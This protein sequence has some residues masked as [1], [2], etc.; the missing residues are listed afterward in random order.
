M[1]DNRHFSRTGAI[2]DLGA[3]RENMIA[4]VKAARE[5]NPEIKALAT[6]KADAYGHGACEV[7]NAVEDI[8]E[9]FSVACTDEGI[10]LREEGGITKPVLILGPVFAEDDED[11]IRYGLT[12][13][14]FT[15]KRL[16][17]LNENAARFA[18]ENGLDPVALRKE[19]EAAG[20]TVGEILALMK[21]GRMQK[22]RAAAVEKAAAAA[23]AD[24]SA[25]K[26]RVRETTLKTGSGRDCFF[27]D[28]KAHV[29]I[30]VDTGMSRIGLMPDENGLRIL[31]AAMELPYVSIDGVFTH[32]A[33]ADEKDKS[34][35]NL[36]LSK[37]QKFKAMAEEAGI[38]I[39]CWHCANTASIIDGIGLKG[40]DL[41]RVGIGLYGMYPS[42]EVRKE[43]VTLRPALTWYAYITYV[44]W[45]EAGT[46]VSYGY[47][48]TADKRMR[49][50]T[51]S[52]GYADG[53]PRSLSLK[54]TEVLV[55]GRRCPI[56]GRICMDQMMIDISAFEEGEVFE[57]VPVILIGGSGTDADSY[58]SAE[59]LA[60]K[61]GTISYE[62]TCGISRRVPRKYLK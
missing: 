2:V 54:G 42:D 39:P 29:H 40:F 20:D 24:P 13:V 16:K 36:A 62:M 23:A 56:L 5:E 41:C 59:E 51:V 34:G 14:I 22:E 35:A 47:K 21:E 61:I 43:R 49:I 18:R 26:N 32:F 17:Q 28:G 4:L 27:A 30:A 55:N 31:K 12:Q 58:I 8:A 10:E 3:I 19:A 57:G 37:F 46:S 6:V 33:T 45:I 11:T 48:Y 44:K 15:V 9:M 25:A 60:E 1:K 7:A 50:G 38:R 53:Y 52:I